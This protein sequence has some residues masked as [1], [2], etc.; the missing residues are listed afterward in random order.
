MFFASQAWGEG[1]V[2]VFDFL[3][4]DPNYLPT[5]C[6]NVTAWQEMFDLSHP[7]FADCLEQFQVYD[8][9]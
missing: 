7:I 8:A 3:I 2:M 5:D 9:I 4:K 1:S 6:D